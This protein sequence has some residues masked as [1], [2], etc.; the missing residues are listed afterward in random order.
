MIVLK[1][2]GVSEGIAV[3][4]AFFID[5]K[6]TKIKK[7]KINESNIAFEIKKFKEAIKKTEEYIKHVKELSLQDLGEEH[8]FIFDVYL[9]LLKDDMLIGETER[10]IKNEKVNAEYALWKVSR[11]LINIFE[12]TE[13]PYIKEKKNDVKHIVDKIIRFMTNDGFVFKETSGEARIAIAHDLSPSELVSLLKQNIVAFAIDLGSKISHT[14]IIARAMGIPAVVGLEKITDNI[15]SSDDTIIVDGFNGVVILDPDKEVLED[16]IVKEKKYR[17]YVK[18]LEK[19]KDVEVKTVDG[20]FV[21]IFSNVEINEE[22]SISN[23]Y[24]AKGIGLYRTEFIYLEKGDVSEDEQFEILKDAVLRN[25]NKP[26]TIRTFDLG[27]EK[28]SNLLPHPDEQN[29]AMGLRA[30]RYSLRFKDIFKTQIKAIHRA[31]VFGDVRIMFPM[32]SG[33]EEIRQAKNVVEECI[34]ELKNEKKEFKEN[35]PLGVMVELPS[36]ALITH[37]INKEV[38]F[39]SVGTN[40][41]IQY[42]LGIDRNNEYVAYLYRP[43]HPAVLTLLRKI[44]KDAQKGGIEVTVCGEMAGDPKYIPVLLGLGYRNLSMSPSAILKAKMIISRVKISE[45]EKLINSLKRCKFARKA[46]EKLEKFIDEHA[47]D[48]FFH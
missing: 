9:L 16:Y 47:S 18:E 8:S 10:F 22:I 12:K 14:S 20:E 27:G 2:I 7:I 46:E 30:I 34:E 28:L 31:A 33:V 42:T 29:P 38:D 40:D 11:K 4:K 36:L 15:I 45:C 44:Y 5:R 48:L 13:D 1:G 35:V 24:K 26:I 17:D 3:G 6:L 25:E 32:I 19:L 23:E 43:T 39:F 41:L 21:N 37:L